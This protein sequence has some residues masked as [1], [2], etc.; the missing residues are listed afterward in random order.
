MIHIENFSIQNYKSLVE[1]EVNIH[2]DLTALI[3]ANGVGKTNV[4]TA[5]MLLKNIAQG[6]RMRGRYR[7]TK[8]HLAHATIDATFQVD[9]EACSLNVNVFFDNI[10]GD[11]E[12][13][14]Y[15]LKISRKP[16][17]W[18]ELEQDVFDYLA[19]LED[20]PD[21]AR[22]QS[23]DSRYLTRDKKLN[24]QLIQL[25]NYLS[26]ISYY[27]ATQFSDP[28][29]SPV[30]FELEENRLLRSSPRRRAHERFLFDLYTTRRDDL[31]AFKRYL[32]TI[33][34]LGVGLVDDID[35]KEMTVPSSSIKV[36]PGGRAEKISSKK[37]FVIPLFKID[38]LVL[39]P[40]QLSE[41][42]FKSLALI[43]YILN[44]D[45]ELLLIEEPEVCV[46]Q[47]L[48]ASIIEL[49]KLQSRTKQVVISTHSDHVLDRLQPENVALVKRGKNGTTVA[50]LSR[51]LSMDDYSALKE[52]LNEAGNLGEY[53]KESDFFNE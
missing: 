41:G 9:S 40:T 2:Q 37:T 1:T 25:T 24:Q 49:I 18:I 31:K 42:T 20:H 27:S 51:A 28:T 19:Y 5:I 50:P 38:G 13:R 36:R 22:Q 30:S 10:D 29:L 14:D 46:H 8:D 43:F 33:G 32:N 34:S 3:G 23:L 45:T 47:G 26:R 15:S 53:W 4:L 44:D 16:G 35:F 48:L 21:A 12:I 17:V 7:T 11:Y 6:D 39:S 52:Y